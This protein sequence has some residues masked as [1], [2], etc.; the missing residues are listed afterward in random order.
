MHLEGLYVLLA[1]SVAHF[2]SCQGNNSIKKKLIL[3]G[4]NY[5]IVCY[6]ILLTKMF[7]NKAQGS[8]LTPM[9]SAGSSKL[10]LSV[11]CCLHMRNIV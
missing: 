8:R 11:V 5:D 6:S 10:C 7:T 4:L 1:W 2:S 3:S 9:F